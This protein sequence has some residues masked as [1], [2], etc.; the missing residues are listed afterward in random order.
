MG[1][2]STPGPR[3][4]TRGAPAAVLAPSS[5]AGPLPSRRS[6]AASG[7]AASKSPAGA[8]AASGGRSRA[9][10]G[11]A[12]G[13]GGGSSSSEEEIV[14]VGPKPR[15]RVAKGGLPEPLGYTRPAWG[16]VVKSIGSMKVHDVEG[17]VV[18]KVCR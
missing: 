10:S 12:G 1:D 13:N 8:G 6:R 16:S 11:D 3:R 15:K 7:A 2:A 17:Q 4:S 9:T 18:I 14:V 5:S